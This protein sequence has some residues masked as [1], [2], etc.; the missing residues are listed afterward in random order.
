MANH[1]SA[2]KRARQNIKRKARNKHY[3][4]SVKKQLKSFLVTLEGKVKEKVGEEFKNL[5]KAV[6]KC[7]SKGIIPQERASRIVGRF[8]KRVNATFSSN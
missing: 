4:L 1:Q 5:T 2:V 3:K 8:A 6:Y 7:A